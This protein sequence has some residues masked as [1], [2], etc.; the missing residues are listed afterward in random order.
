MDGRAAEICIPPPVT[1]KNISKNKTFAVL[2]LFLAELSFTIKSIKT[3]K[4]ECPMSMGYGGYARLISEDSASVLYEYGAFNWNIPRC[5]NSDNVCDGS[6]T[7]DK[8]CFIEPEIHQKIKKMPSGRKRLIIKRIPRDV[9]IAPKLKARKIA[10]ENCS[11][12]WHLG[13]GP[14]DEK[15]DMMAFRLLY[16]IFQEYQESGEVPKKV[17]IFC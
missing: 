15:I 14:N 13:T 11:H 5:K 3:K 17:S 1:R 2:I 7:I 8:D 16:K 9:D 4:E 6:I 10:I 12:C